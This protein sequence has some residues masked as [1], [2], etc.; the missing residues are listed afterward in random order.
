LGETS[1]ARALAL[2]HRGRAEI[3][4]QR[5]KMSS[6]ALTFIVPD[7][8]RML[9]MVSFRGRKAVLSKRAIFARD[10]ETCQYCGLRG[11]K[12]TV[13]HVHPKSRGGPDTWGNLTTACVGCNQRKNN[14]TPTEAGMRLRRI[15]REPSLVQT[16]RI[17]ARGQSWLDLMADGAFSLG[18]TFADHP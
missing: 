17:T 14:R 15:P 9:A 16:I 4:R 12:L 2:V 6:V 7:I 1:I 5:G 10:N 13:D 8:I 18:E 11:G 3:V